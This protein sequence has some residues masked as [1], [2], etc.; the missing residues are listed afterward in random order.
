MAMLEQAGAT[1]VDVTDATSP[2]RAT[3]RRA[4]L[5]PDLSEDAIH[6]AV[7]DL[8]DLVLT[9]DSW[10]TTIEHRNAAGKAEGARRKKRGVKKGIPDI[11]IVWNGQTYVVE[12]KTRTGSLDK[13]QI[14]VRADMIAAGAIWAL[15]RSVDDVLDTLGGWGIPIRAVTL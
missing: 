4:R 10:W 9:T 11:W 8:L 15:C 13:A 2:D 14:E 7:R 3:K 12:L 1:V 6:A 5:L